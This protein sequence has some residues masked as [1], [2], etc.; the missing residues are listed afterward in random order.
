MSRVVL[1]PFPRLTHGSVAWGQWSF[2]ANGRQTTGQDLCDVWD[3]NSE[4]SFAMTATVDSSSAQSLGIRSPELIITVSCQET[5]YSVSRR[6]RL[7]HDKNRMSASC[8]LTVL[9]E[10]IAQSVQLRAQIVSAAPAE[11]LAE[12]PWMSRRIVAE[13][14]VATIPLSSDLTG[15]P[16]SAQ[17]FRESNSLEAPWRVSV[18]ATE[19]SDSFANSVR[20]YLNV[21]F[22]LVRELIAG[23]PRPHVE[24]ALSTSITQVLLN[25]ARKLH[26]ESEDG[27]SPSAVA[28][29]YP[30]SLAAAAERAAEQYLRMSLSEAVAEMRLRPDTFEYRLSAGVGALKEKA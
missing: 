29:E 7:V 8:S 21:D 13:L 12:A 5:A 18:N 20:L 23:K 9:G 2:T 1:Y 30:E 3:S 6:S 17:S 26:D 25:S 19:L 28:A 27:K 22:P 4:L 11:E 15:F 16:T 10:D 24:V 14:P